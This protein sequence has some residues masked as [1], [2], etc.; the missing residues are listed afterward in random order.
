MFSILESFARP[1]TTPTT[2]LM[3]YDKNIFSS[4]KTVNCVMSS[5]TCSAVS[6]ASSDYLSNYSLINTV[7]YSKTSNTAQV[8]NCAVVCKG[9]SNCIAFNSTYFIDSKKPANTIF[10]CSYYKAKESESTKASDTTSTQQPDLD[11]PPLEQE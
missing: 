6:P 3:T 10:S 8:Q 7:N 2:P 1:T 11:S 9:D 5:S 4:T